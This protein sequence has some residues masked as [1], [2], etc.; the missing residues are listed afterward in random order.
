MAK[1]IVWNITFEAT[2]QSATHGR[3]SIPTRICEAL[4]L[5]SG[6]SFIA[7]MSNGHVA[8]MFGLPGN[9]ALRSLSARETPSTKPPFQALAS[10]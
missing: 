7:V 5:S 8:N 4:G 1:P 9:P 3:F 10:L 6:D 2:V